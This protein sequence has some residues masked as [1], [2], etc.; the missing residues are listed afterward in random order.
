MDRTCVSTGRSRKPRGPRRLNAPTPNVGDRRGGNPATNGCPSCTLLRPAGRHAMVVAHFFESGQDAVYV[1]PSR[2]RTANGR[3]SSAGQ[4]RV[5]SC[6]R[7]KGLGG[8]T[9]ARPGVQGSPQRERHCPR[10]QLESR[11]REAQGRVILLERGLDRSPVAAAGTGCSPANGTP[12]ELRR[13]ARPCVL[14]I[15][16]PLRSTMIYR[17][18]RQKSLGCLRIERNTNILGVRNWSSNFPADRAGVG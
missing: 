17:N 6:D 7:R 11:V 1:G 16:L 3:R 2:E 5:H 13:L 14:S 4:H 15:A 8:A 9:S 12:E 18:V 10:R